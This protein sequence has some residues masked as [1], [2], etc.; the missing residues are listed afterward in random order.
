MS[1][2]RRA[3]LVR[4][5]CLVRVVLVRRA[6]LAP[7]RRLVRR[8]LPTPRSRVMRRVCR[9]RVRRPG[10]RPTRKVLLGRGNSLIH[11]VAARNVASR[12]LAQPMK[13][14]AAYTAP[15]FC[16]RTSWVMSPRR[17][18]LCFPWCRVG[19][20]FRSR[21]HRWLGRTIR[22]SEK[23]LCDTTSTSL[24]SR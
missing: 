24:P 23:C 3:R 19:S 10:R 7:K 21:N 1:T 13:K 4:T 16:P 5:M 11:P 22:S 12:R 20:G 14:G 15:E 9:V 8:V 18:L 6:R 17:C 2:V